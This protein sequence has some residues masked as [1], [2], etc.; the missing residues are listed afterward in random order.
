MSKPFDVAKAIAS[1][2]RRENLRSAEENAKWVVRRYKYVRLRAKSERETP[3]HDALSCLHGTSY[4]LPCV[5]C[6]RDKNEANNNLAKL[7]LKLSIT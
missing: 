1:L 6:R 4:T 2:E 7:K 5:K 3:V